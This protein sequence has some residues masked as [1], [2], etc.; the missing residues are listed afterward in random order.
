MWA[1]RP[2]LSI[3]ELELEPE[4]CQ[5]NYGVCFTSNHLSR[6]SR[7]R[8]IGERTDPKKAKDLTAT[9]HHSCRELCLHVE[10]AK[11]VRDRTLLGNCGPYVPGLV[12]QNLR[13]GCRKDTKQFED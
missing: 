4:L 1:G 10:R 13:Q 11:F 6:V 2:G 3:V 9:R 5:L 7:L 8:D 12:Q